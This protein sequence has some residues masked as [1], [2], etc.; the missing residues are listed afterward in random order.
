LP[1][2]E[3]WEQYALLLHRRHRSQETIALY[4][5][6]LSKLWAFL[7]DQQHDWRTV[8]PELVDAWLDGRV[9]AEWTRNTYGRVVRRFYACAVSRGWLDGPNPLEDWQP[10][11]APPPR[12]RALP[13]DAIG[14]LLA[15]VDP[16]IRMM[17]L[18][19]YH[20]ALRVGE[21]VR[22]SV[23]DLALGADPP[24]VRVDGKG[25]KQT[26]MPLSPA[27]VGP[28]RA[29]LLLRPARGP[30]IPNY[31]DPTR[32]LHPKYAAHLL[33]SVMR[34]VVGD[35]G[36][37]LRHTAARQ[38]RRQTHDPFLVR[39]A[40]RHAGLQTLDVYTQDPERLAAALGQLPDPLK[41]EA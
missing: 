25:G 18:L 37:A 14:A 40:L 22:L 13:L 39:D 17:V 28:L 12:P 32:Y 24:M 33:A 31:R 15:V 9:R 36:H 23:E 16:R 1:S 30:L 29:W 10:P 8:T 34:P 3:V 38:L 5:V 4:E 6:A 35:S 11:P 2:N 26:W 20:Q 41:T 27:L 19:G 21:I 7:A